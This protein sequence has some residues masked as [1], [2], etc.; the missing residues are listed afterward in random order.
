MPDLELYHITCKAY[1]IGK[2]PPMDGE[3]LYHLSTQT[4]QRAW[5]DE[6]LDAQKSNEKPSRK[7]THYAC[8]SILNCKALKSTISKPH[9]TPRIY[10]VIMTNPSKS[11][12]ALV[13][14]LFQ[15]GQ[16]HNKNF[17]VAKEYWNPTMDWRFYEYLSDKMEIIEEVPNNDLPPMGQILFWANNNDGFIAD[18]KLA[19]E[20][21]NK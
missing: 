9:C 16:N 7:K 4:D 8:D 2:V 17:D 14:H 20:K 15:L 3:S 12:M 5:I 10:K 21:F 11:P 13:N 18:S 1:P 6:F 19:N